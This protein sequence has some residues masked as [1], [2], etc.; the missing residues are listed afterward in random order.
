[1]TDPNQQDV[2]R[3]HEIDGIQEYDNNLPRWWVWS[4][5]LCIV[6]AIGYYFHY[7]WLDIG[8][9]GVERWEEAESRALEL[10]LANNPDLPEE[11]LVELSLDSKAIAAGKE[12]FVKANCRQ[13]HGP[14][15]FGIIGPNLRDDYWIWGSNMK[16]IVE[17]ITNGRERKVGSVVKQ[18]PKQ[19]L[20]PKDIQNL[21]A[22]IADLNRRTQKAD[23]A[24]AK[25]LKAEG[26]LQPIEY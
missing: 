10:K 19:N 6:W 23:G 22:Y 24:T 13:C 8:K 3:E 2:L 1:M 26:E 14:D 5:V 21:A 20:S 7:H 11:L 17:T 9:V 12:V 4:F 18:M 15:A 25:G 16:D